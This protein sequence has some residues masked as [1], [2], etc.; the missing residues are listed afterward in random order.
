MHAWGLAVLVALCAS[1]YHGTESLSCK[2]RCDDGSCPDGMTC[3]GGL[4]T[5]GATCTAATPTCGAIGQPCC[6][7]GAACTGNGVCTNGT[8][9]ECVVEVAP[10]RRHACVREHDGTVWCSGNDQSGQLGDST[11]SSPRA[12]FV[13]A[14]D[15]SGP[16]S[17]AIAIAAGHDHSC[18]VR[19]GGSVW[20]WGS[21]GSGELGDNSS[22]AS[23][24]AVQVQTQAGT[25]LTDVVEIAAGAAY[26]CARQS[27]G[28][29]WCWGANNHGQLGDATFIN[30]PQAVEVTG[31]TAATAISAGHD[32][33]CAL[34]GGEARCW[35]RNDYGQLGDGTN[36]VTGQPSSAGSAAA[37]ATG[38]YGSCLVRP[39]STVAC[40]GAAWLERIGNGAT[41]SVST[42]TQAL[43]G[44]GGAPLTGVTAIAVGG[45]A[46]ALAA[47]HR[48]LCWGINPH[49]QIGNGA[50]GY[51]PAAVLD[52]GGELGD[53]DRIVAHYAHTCAHRTGDGAWLC[54]GRNTEGEYGDGT[55]T[56]RAMPTPIGAT[57]N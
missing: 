37:I 53:I 21:N 38:G 1:C 54:W 45:V 6:E 3:V 52:G 42:P 34:D 41:A 2:I 24:V 31:I 10:G 15:A 39:D 16:I 47:D 19:S 5:T 11:T 32:Q 26:T 46:C 49:G 7:T 18:A 44:A 27:G 30:H 33:A 40:M 57:C 56:N 13:Q 23:S 17:D 36:N 50:G 20:C 4:C 8:C 55:F 35:G 25:P 29:V 12:S 51:Y 48:V 9:T 43:V 14:S 28:N 22:N